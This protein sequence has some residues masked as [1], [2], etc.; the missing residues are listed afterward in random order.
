MRESDRRLFEAAILVN[1]DG[2][3][4]PFVEF[5]RSEQTKALEAML[6]A[7]DEKQIFGAQGAY[8]A[9][10]RVLD[11]IEQAQSLFDKRGG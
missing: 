8:K 9:L 5:L 2:K 4:K 10:Q 11:L 7:T 6:A 1:S 3:L